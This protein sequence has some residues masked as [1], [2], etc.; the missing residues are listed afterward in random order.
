MSDGSGATKAR[1]PPPYSCVGMEKLDNL[2]L[3]RELGLLIHTIIQL[4]S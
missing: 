4:P 3:S 1:E 2:R